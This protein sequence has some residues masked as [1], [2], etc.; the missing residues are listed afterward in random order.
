MPPYFLANRTKNIN[1]LI[2]FISFIFCLF[3]SII[4]SSHH[5]INK[6][7]HQQITTPQT[8]NQIAIKSQL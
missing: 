2:N 8:Q 6:S 1:Q 3:P 5:H 4:T 7:S